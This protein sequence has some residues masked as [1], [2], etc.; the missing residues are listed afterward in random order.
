VK[1]CTRYTL[2]P[3]R[4][5]FEASRQSPNAFEGDDITASFRINTLS[6]NITRITTRENEMRITRNTHGEMKIQ[7]L[8]GNSCQNKR[9]LGDILA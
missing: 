1:E 7:I 5:S 6:P 2:Q 4:L 3:E 9:P 8:F